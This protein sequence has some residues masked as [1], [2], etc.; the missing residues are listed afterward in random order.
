MPLSAY[1]CSAYSAHEHH[2]CYQIEGPSNTFLQSVTTT[3]TQYAQFDIRPFQT[4]YVEK[5]KRET[6]KNVAY[7]IKVK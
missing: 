5:I 7:T 2:L 6:T 4:K 3:K 1:D